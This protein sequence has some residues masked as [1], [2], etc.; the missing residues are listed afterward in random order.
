MKKLAT[1]GLFILSGL[2][3]AVVTAFLGAC[4]TN[5]SDDAG[6]ILTVAWVIGVLIYAITFA[7]LYNPYL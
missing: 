2:I 3:F 7:T 1:F 5:N 6:E 4:I